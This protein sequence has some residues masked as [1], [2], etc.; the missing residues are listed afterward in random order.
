MS[1]PDSG[2]L[3]ERAR[4][5]IPGGVNSPVRAFGSVGGEPVF[6]ARGR[7]SRLYDVSGREYLDVMA[8]W[9]PLILGH[10][11]SRVE[12]AVRQALERG[13]TFGASTAAEVELAEMIVE[14]VPSVEQVRLVSS[15]TEATMTALR[16][17]RGATGRDRVIKFEGCYH[18]HS[19][20]F[21]IKAG[22][23]ALTL[24][25]PS[26]PGVPAA[27]AEL[28]LNAQF[29]DLESVRACFEAHPGE[30]AA[31]I[32]EPIAGNMG[33]VPPRP[34][35]LPGLRKLCDENG[36]VLIFDEVITGFR[37]APGGAQ[38][39]LDV[40]PDLTTLG[41][42]LG[43][44]LPL[45]ALGGRRDL[46]EQLAPVGPVYQAGTLSGNPL[47]TAA[48]LAM[49]RVLKEGGRELYESLER[50]GSRL[51]SGLEAALTATGVT[52]QVQRVGSM[53]TLFFNPVPVESMSSLEKLDTA[54]YG[55]FFHGLLERGVCFPPSQ[56]EA[57]FVSTAHSSDDVDRLVEVA[58]E[59][60][61]HLVETA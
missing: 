20:S 13:T 49:L 40:R 28:T 38:E 41:K 51:A 4:R 36:T 34:E 1:T 27:L 37:V 5:V 57:F 18:G 48:G 53:M 2:T 61:R 12:S 47:A 31:V 15:G 10:A 35:F 56:Y 6:F 9:G 43:G 30:I 45:G 16:L 58:G 11:D 52:G 59:T 50:S 23:G 55:R 3:F 39:R 33:V 14:L 25:V 32:V 54:F 22:S 44:G 29:N 7:G 19:D 60:L 24:G 21:L 8:S 26:S 42:I 46:M 17:A